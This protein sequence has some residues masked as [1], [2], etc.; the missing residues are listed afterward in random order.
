MQV[1][2]PHRI[3]WKPHYDTGNIMIDRQHREVID[4]VNL[5][6]VADENE[7]GAMVLDEAFHAL[8]QYVKIHFSDEEQLLDTVDSPHLH[9]QRELHQVLVREMD[10]RWRHKNGIS[11]RQMVQELGQ[12]AEYRLLKHFLT[13]DS[14]TFLSP[15]FTE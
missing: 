15:P 8:R 7:E 9:Q 13:A 3:P 11:A 14:E 1:D 6:L 12:W 5:L 2:P 10:A 4:L